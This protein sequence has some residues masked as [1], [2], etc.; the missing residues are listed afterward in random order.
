MNPD[1]EQLTLNYQ[2]D[3]FVLRVFIDEQA[4]E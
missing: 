1:I 2:R 4:S 3:T